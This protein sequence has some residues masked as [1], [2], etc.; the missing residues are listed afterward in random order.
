VSVV[1]KVRKLVFIGILIMLLAVDIFVLA[2]AGFGADAP[3]KKYMA[4]SNV[5]DQNG[6]VIGC[7]CPKDL[8]D[9]IC[10]INT[11]QPNDPGI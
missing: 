10:I 6:N 7:S 8:G 4:G 3:K 2:A 1:E 9:C 11:P 5:K